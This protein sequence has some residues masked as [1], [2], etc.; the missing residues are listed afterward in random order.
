MTEE[1]FERI[2]SYF[3]KH[4]VYDKLFVAM[5]KKY[6]ARGQLG[7]I[8]VLDDLTMEERNTLSGFIGA[9]L[10]KEKV[11]KISFSAL[12]KAL[13]KSRFCGVHWEE[14]L[15]SYAGTPLLSNKE[16]RRQQKEEQDIFKE[17]C[18]SFCTKEN[19]KEWLSGLLYEKQSRCRIIGK[20]LETDREE[21]KRLL[22]NVIYGLEHLPAD[23]GKKQTLPVYAAEITGNPHYFDEGTAACRLLLDYGE[24]RFGQ[25]EGNVSG[26]EQRDAVLYR[27]GILKDDLSNLCLAYGVTGIKTNG[28]AHEG[29]QGFCKEKQ[30]MQMTLNTLTGLS[31]LETA[32]IHYTVYIVENPAVFS[33]LTKKYPQDTFLCTSGQLKLASYVAMD[34]FP[35]EYTFYYAG[36]FDPEGLQIAQGLKKRYGKRLFLWNY[37][38][39]YYKQAISELVLDASRLK[40][41]EK[42]EVAELEEI[43]DCL[44]TYKKAA[45]Q[46]K[47]LDAYVVVYRGLEKKL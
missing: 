2:I 39:E 9:D 42:I 7:G 3:K 13:E 38:K 25:I 31:R 35:E 4:T 1:N 17:V 37:K 40:K 43:K 47:M 29:L 5:R 28:T 10:G 19:V 32:S 23:E 34:L 45:Y 44:L 12:C 36:D 24:Q 6:T 27:L 16:K 22:K 26:I 8:F 33:Y 11:V 14:I 30:A 15:E 21:A 41:L 46:E 20:H 18:L